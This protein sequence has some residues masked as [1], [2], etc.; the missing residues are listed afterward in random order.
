MKV[1]LLNT[2]NKKRN[3]EIQTTLEHKNDLVHDMIEN[4]H[5]NVSSPVQH[6]KVDILRQCA[7]I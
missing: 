7:Q 5:D 2:A 1:K 3:N 4:L 6:D